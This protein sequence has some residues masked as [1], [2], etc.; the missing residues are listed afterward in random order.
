MTIKKPFGF[1][2][3]LPICPCW[4]L[5]KTFHLHPAHPSFSICTRPIRAGG[6]YRP[7][8]L[9]QSRPLH[10]CR[11]GQPC[12]LVTIHNHNHHNDLHSAHLSQQ[13][14]TCLPPWSALPT[15]GPSVVTLNKAQRTL[16]V[17]GGGLHSFLGMFYTTGAIPG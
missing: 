7:A 9:S 16:S 13:A 6:Q 5:S 4:S 11:P 17:G 3:P 2:L 8:H 14:T 15:I 1:P 10:P 12:P